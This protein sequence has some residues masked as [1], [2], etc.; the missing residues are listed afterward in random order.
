MSF[1]DFVGIHKDKTPVEKLWLLVVTMNMMG[2]CRVNYA[3][4][5]NIESRTHCQSELEGQRQRAEWLYDEIK[6][7]LEGAKK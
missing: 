3:T 5:E 7:A 2:T 1:E 4:S 6:A